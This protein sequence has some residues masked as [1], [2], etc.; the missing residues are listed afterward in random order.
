MQIEIHTKKE[1]KASLTLP[2]TLKLRHCNDYGGLLDL[3][4]TDCTF[5]I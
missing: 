3:S 5:Q 2:L 4:T 1:K